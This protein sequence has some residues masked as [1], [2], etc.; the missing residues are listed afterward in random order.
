MEM[1]PAHRH[2]CRACVFLGRDVAGSDGPQPRI[3]DLYVHPDKRDTGG[4]MLI[5]RYASER[6]AYESFFREDG[7][8]DFAI[9]PHYR[10]ILS[11]AKTRGVIRR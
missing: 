4:I 5:R 8:A 11:R 1:T 9:P 7:I 3:V 6:P 2:D 10:E